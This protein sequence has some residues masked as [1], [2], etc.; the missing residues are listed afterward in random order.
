MGVKFFKYAMLFEP[1][2]YTLIAQVMNL[3]VFSTIFTLLGCRLLFG[4]HG[5]GIGTILLLV[6]ISA[7]AAFLVE[8]IF[9]N[10]TA[11]VGNGTTVASADE[12]IELAT[13]VARQAIDRLRDAFARFQ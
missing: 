9:S 12:A 7:S 5:V 6:S 3:I 4:G 13:A 2:T 10:D 11:M 8:S 1:K